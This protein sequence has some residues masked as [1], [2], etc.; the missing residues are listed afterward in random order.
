MVD[1]TSTTVPVCPCCGGT[2]VQTRNDGI[3]IP[4]PGCTHTIEITPA[5]P[6]PWVPYNPPYQP[7]Y[8]YY[9]YYPYPPDYPYYPYII[10]WC[11]VTARA[12]S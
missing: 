1:S 6:T 9:P 5:I 10:T 8:P 4:C 7:D 11:H 12:R 2:G 3:K